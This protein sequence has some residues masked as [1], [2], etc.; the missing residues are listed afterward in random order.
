MT[1][2]AAPISTGRQRLG[3]QRLNYETARSNRIVSF[4]T[5][6]E[7]WKLERIAEQER[8]SI[9][10]VVPQILSGFLKNSYKQHTTIFKSKKG[11]L[12]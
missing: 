3:R 10:A 7:L 12:S 5:N 6:S 2:E 11:E 9:S 8:K 1:K 4:V